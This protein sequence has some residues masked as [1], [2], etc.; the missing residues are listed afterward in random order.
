M[1]KILVFKRKQPTYLESSSLSDC[2]ADVSLTAKIEDLE[3]GPWTTRKLKIP[4]S[5][6][7]YLIIE[8]FESADGKRLKGFGKTEPEFCLGKLKIQV[9]SAFGFDELTLFPYAETAYTDTDFM[10]YVINYPKQGRLIVI[11]SL[12]LGE[13]IIQCKL[14]F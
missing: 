3:C 5:S 9:Q 1:A 8:C 6:S 2:D 4:T 10:S 7:G 13:N 14:W 11:L 12:S